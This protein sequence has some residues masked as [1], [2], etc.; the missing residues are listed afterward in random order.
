[1]TNPDANTRPIPVLLLGGQENSLSVIRSLSSHGVP[2][3][4]SAPNSCYALLSRH[5]ARRFVVPDGADRHAYW[6]ELLLGAGH[7]ELHG[8]VVFPANDEA[9]EFMAAHRA[10]LGRRFALDDHQSNQQ[11]AL[12]DKQ[13]T[14]EMARSLG[15][16]APQYWNIE[17]AEDVLAI[18]GDV[19]FP[20]IIKPI[21][22]H[23]FQRVYKKKLLV[24]N[25]FAELERRVTECLDQ[26]L[27]IMVCELV[28]GPDTLLS[29]YYTYI[30]K[31]NEH[32]FH[33][34]K[35]MLR[36]S[37]VNFGGGVYHVTQWLPETAEMGKKFFRG[38]GFRG[39]GNIEFKRDLRDGQLKVIECNAR[40]TA[41]QELLVAAGIDISWIIYNHVTGG[42]VPQIERFKEN[43]H[44]WYFADD[45]DAYRE[46]RAMGELSLPGYLKSIAHRQVLPFF[47]LTDP[48]PALSK[49]WNTFGKRVLQRGP[50]V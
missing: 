9:I 49:A 31:N 15:V 19:D 42:R 27:E 32:L 7:P 1:M 24:V 2:V 5:L 41:A 22:S 44:F 34:T 11:R 16:G 37:P 30:D 18:E 23:V 8:S 12:L 29:S 35:R 47:K 20:V 33:F 3:S 6:E 46:L 38:I 25:D 26:G 21:H 14:L 48:K 45:F 50:G 10:D 17:K 40:F 39:L 36:R 28:P 4:L 13:V 43:L